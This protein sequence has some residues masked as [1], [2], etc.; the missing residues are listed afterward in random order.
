MDHRGFQR[1]G[2]REWRQDAGH[3]GGEGFADGAGDLM[4]NAIRGAELVVVSAIVSYAT[5]PAGGDSP[6]APRSM[7]NRLTW[8]LRTSG[9]VMRIAHEHTSAPIGFEDMKAIL[10]R[11]PKG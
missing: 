3:A 1:F 7:H 6:A 9:H 2:C 5:Q 4:I 8:V 11:Q 10:Q